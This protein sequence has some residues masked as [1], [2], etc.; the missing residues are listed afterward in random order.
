MRVGPFDF[1]G[2]GSQDANSQGVITLNANFP[3]GYYFGCW[4]PVHRPFT[5][6]SGSMICVDCD[7]A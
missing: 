1:G 6:T 2:G 5:Q 4:D 7:D 3:G